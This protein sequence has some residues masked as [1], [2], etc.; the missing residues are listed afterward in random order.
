M[1]IY[2][3]FGHL[4]GQKPTS[5]LA[6]QRFHESPVEGEED[7]PPDQETRRAVHSNGGLLWISVYKLVHL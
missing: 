6:G 5:V 4:H 2:I 7:V 3:L 1:L